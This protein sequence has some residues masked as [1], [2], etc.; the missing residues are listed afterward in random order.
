M[1]LMKNLGLDISE[2]GSAVSTLDALKDEPDQSV[3]AAVFRSLE[4]APLDNIAIVSILWGFS[5]E[6]FTPSFIHTFYFYSS[7]PSKLLQP[8]IKIDCQSERRWSASRLLNEVKSLASRLLTDSGLK[9]G[10]VV[11]FYCP[12][13]DHHAIALLAVSS[14]GAIYTGSGDHFPFRKC[15]FMLHILIYMSPFHSSPSSFFIFFYPSCLTCHQSI[16]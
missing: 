12:N 10:D 16:N 2:T 9:K 6:T 4:S 8:K 15:H 7:T 1:D 11:A 14:L 3:A 13:S 5:S